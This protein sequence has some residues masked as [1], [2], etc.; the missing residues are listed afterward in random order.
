MTYAVTSDPL[1]SLIAL[2]TS[3]FPDLIELGV[4]RLIF[5]RHRGLSHNPFF[6]APLFLLLWT[7]LTVELPS[8]SDSL[9][10]TL[11]LFFYGAFAGIALHL[12]TDALSVGGI[13]LLGRGSRM[14]LHTYKT[15]HISENAVAAAIVVLSTVSIYLF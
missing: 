13:P 1:M 8:I 9:R 11:F 10:E 6:W 14:A 3:V 5:R 4:G 2:V 7:L 15:F 12:L